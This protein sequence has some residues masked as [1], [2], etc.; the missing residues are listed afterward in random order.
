[1]SLERGLSEYCINKRTDPSSE[2]GTDMGFSP[3]DALHT[4]L[5]SPSFPFPPFAGDAGQI[6]FRADRTTSA[7]KTSTAAV[8]SSTMKSF[9]QLSHKARRSAK[10]CLS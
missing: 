5:A 3:R 7:T 2:G 6:K 9:D 8:T 10:T 4:P 1:M